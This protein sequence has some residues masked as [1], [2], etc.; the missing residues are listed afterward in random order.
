MPEHQG[1]GEGE[2][3]IRQLTAK[4]QKRRHRSTR[5]GK[6]VPKR[7]LENEALKRKRPD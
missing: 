4:S 3:N 7:L 5:D 2:A 1:R 6:G